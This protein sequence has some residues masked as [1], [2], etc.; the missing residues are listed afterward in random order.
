M[1][2]ISRDDWLVALSEAGLHHESDPDAITACEFAEMMGLPLTTARHQ[3]RA[4]VSAGKATETRKR[5]ITARG[6][7]VELLAYRLAK[8]AKR[9]AK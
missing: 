1:S 6:H 3:L 4:L 5:N 7:R 9:S 2:G 8:P